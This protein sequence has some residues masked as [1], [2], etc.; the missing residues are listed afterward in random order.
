MRVELEV[1][2]RVTQEDGCS[3]FIHSRTTASRFSSAI[4]NL[5]GA[6]PPKLRASYIK[7]AVTRTLCNSKTLRTRRPLLVR[8]AWFPTRL[9]VVLGRFPTLARELHQVRRPLANK[10]FVSQSRARGARGCALRPSSGAKRCVSS[11]RRRATS[12]NGRLPPPPDLRRAP[13]PRREGH[14]QSAD[15]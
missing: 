5:R 8:V 12:R 15:G 6:P 9:L 2:R 13:L 4:L 14:R 1:D 3:Q 7:I 10:P 11:S